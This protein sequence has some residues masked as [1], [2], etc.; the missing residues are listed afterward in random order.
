MLMIL[1]FVVDE[2]NQQHKQAMID[3]FIHDRIENNQTFRG[4]NTSYDDPEYTSIISNKFLNLIKD[5]FDNLGDQI[6][7]VELWIYVQNNIHHR[8]G[9]HNHATTSTI[10]AVYYIDPPKD[11]GEIQFFYPRGDEKELTVKPEVDKIYIWPYWLYHRVLP[12]K[13]SSWRISV[14]LEYYCKTRP[15]IKSKN[16][17][18][19]L[20]MANTY[21]TFSSNLI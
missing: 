9:W 13:D 6:N 17:L 11:G 4:N 21:L 18:Y 20:V 14:N 12:Q 2:I 8:T 3:K 7:E 15:I 16:L 5:N 19:D 10:N 1:P